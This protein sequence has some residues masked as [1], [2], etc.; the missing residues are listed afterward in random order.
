MFLKIKRLYNVRRP[1]CFIMETGTQHMVVIKPTVVRFQKKKIIIN[2]E[3]SLL[4]KKKKKKKKKINRKS[5]RLSINFFYSLL[6]SY[7]FYFILFRNQLNQLLFNW[8]TLPQVDPE[9]EILFLFRY[10]RTAS[11]RSRFETGCWQFIKPP[12]NCRSQGRTL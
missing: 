9:N 2:F 12:S 1:D 7:F 4:A 6:R 8:V 5:T 11:N 10:C 3:S